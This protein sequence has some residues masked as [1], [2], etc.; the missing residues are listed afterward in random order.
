V[1]LP[2]ALVALTLVVLRQQRSGKRF[3]INDPEVASALFN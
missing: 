1:P 3:S 2:T